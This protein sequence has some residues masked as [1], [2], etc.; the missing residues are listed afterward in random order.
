MNKLGVFLATQEIRTV[1]NHFDVNNDGKISY[2]ELIN[3][4]RVSQ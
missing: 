3:V 2:D 1:Q 4:L